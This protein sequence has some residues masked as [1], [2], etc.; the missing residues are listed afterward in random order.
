MAW[1]I[2]SAVVRSSTTAV[3]PNFAWPR[4]VNTA[5]R[6]RSSRPSR[7]GV[8]DVGEYAVHQLPRPDDGARLT[9]DEHHHHLVQRLR[10]GPTRSVARRWAWKSC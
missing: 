1:H 3:R 7:A 9:S 10:Y 8:A 4:S 2:S 6:R 5:S